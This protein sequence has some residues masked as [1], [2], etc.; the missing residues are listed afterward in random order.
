M[1]QIRFV[2]TIIY[3]SSQTPRIVVIWHHNLMVST[4]NSQLPLHCHFRHCYL[5]SLDALDLFYSLNPP[6]SRHTVICCFCGNGGV[7]W[8]CLLSNGCIFLIL[9]C[10]D[11][12]LVTRDYMRQI[13]THGELHPDSLHILSSNKDAFE[14]LF[15]EF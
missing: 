5:P 10:L 14:Y 6:L 4:I 1:Y 3:H 13:V 11:L 9:L 2:A 15:G 8:D 12:T 7:F